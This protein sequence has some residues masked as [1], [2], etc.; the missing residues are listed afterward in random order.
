MVPLISAAILPP[1]TALYLLIVLLVLDISETYVQ[2]LVIVP[3]TY[4]LGSIPWGY[5]VTHMARRIDVRQYGSG[6]TGMSNVLRTAGGRLA[7]VVLILD[8]AKGVLAVLLARAV[9]GSPVAEVVAALLVLAGHNWS[10]LLGFKGG[11]GI[12]TGSGALALM[13]PLSVAAALISFI[14]VTLFTRYLSLGSI[15]AVFVAFIALVVLTLLRIPIPQS[16]PPPIYLL[17][18]ALGATMIIWQ[19]RDNIQ[20]L[21]QGTE[22]RLGQPAERLATPA[23][24][25][26]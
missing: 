11:R 12:L 19:H 13:S 6:K 2:Y 15:I 10:I 8:L 4:I 17:Y 22:R 5:L 20:R 24:E 25:Q 21:L 3:L 7:A 23:G 1:L 18:T 9:A 16:E 26:R 14:P